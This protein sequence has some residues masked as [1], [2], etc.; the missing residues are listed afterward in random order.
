MRRFEPLAL[1]LL[2]ARADAPP[3]IGGG[4]RPGEPGRVVRVPGI[5]PRLLGDVEL[6]LEQ[7]DLR[8][9]P[10]LH[11]L[12]EA[13]QPLAFAIDQL[14]AADDLAQGRPRGSDF[15]RLRYH[16]RVLGLV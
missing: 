3:D 9:A 5:G 1:G 10:K 2:A 12:S 15:D 14:A 8:L 4:I 13:C 7:R 6:D 16:R 11:A